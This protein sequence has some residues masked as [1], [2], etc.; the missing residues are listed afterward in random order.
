MRGTVIA[1]N[2][3]GRVRLSATF[4]LVGSDV[5]TVALA[6]F[7]VRGGLFLLLLPGVVLPSV[8]GIAGAIGVHAFTFS[9]AVPDPPEMMAPAW[10][11]RL[12]GGAVCPAMNPSTF[13][14][15]TKRKCGD[16]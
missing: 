4:G 15:S 8:L 6:G 3:L 5:P 11:I 1:P 16:W 9:G 12:P 7:L 14:I 10:P 13:S 2:W